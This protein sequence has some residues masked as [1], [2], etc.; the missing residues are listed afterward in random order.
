MKK[1]ILIGMTI[2]FT[3]ASISQATIYRSRGIGYLGGN[4]TYPLTQRQIM[5]REAAIMDAQKSLLAQISSFKLSAD[6]RVQDKVLSSEEISRSIEGV[7]RDARIESE[8]QLGKVAYEV[9]MIYGDKTEPKKPARKQTAK[10]DLK[11]RMPLEV[12]PGVYDNGLDLTPGAKNPAPLERTQIPSRL[13]RLNPI[14]TQTV[15]VDQP[16]V[17]ASQGSDDE[18]PDWLKIYEGD[19]QAVASQGDPELKDQVRDLKRRMKL[20]DETINALKKTLKK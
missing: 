19:P 17:E 10:L 11:A 8:K 9:T 3:A 15:E 14:F 18:M 4:D 13:Q 2:L 7:L 5:A 16:Q 6:A 20:R 12:H 1:A